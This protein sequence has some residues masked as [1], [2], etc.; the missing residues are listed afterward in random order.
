MKNLLSGILI[1]VIALC[2]CTAII[3]HCTVDIEDEILPDIPIKKAIANDAT[4]AYLEYIMPQLSELNKVECPTYGF[5][6]NEETAA[7]I[8]Q[9]MWFQLYDNDIYK[10]GNYIEVISYEYKKRPL[11][12]VKLKKDIYIENSTVLTQ[13]PMAIIDKITGKILAIS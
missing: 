13:S 4:V 6:P 2:A 8:A 7:K 1:V 11:W 3:M 9:K 12:Y 10:Q 5:I